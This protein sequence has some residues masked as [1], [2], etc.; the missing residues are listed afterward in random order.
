PVIYLQSAD[1]RTGGT[2]NPE[3]AAER[4]DELAEAMGDRHYYVCVGFGVRGPD[5][6]IEVMA[7]GAH[8]AIIGTQLVRAAEEG[9]DAITALVDG[10]APALVGR[11]LHRAKEVG[12]CPPHTRRGHRSASRS[13]AT[14]ACRSTSPSPARSPS[15]SPTEN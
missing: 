9:P 10:V 2:F 3:K 4:L 15:P 6:V 14:T 1:L 13:A 12:R 11:A 8:G 7:A 5:E